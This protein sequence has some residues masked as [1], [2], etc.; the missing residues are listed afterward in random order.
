[1]WAVVLAYAGACLVWGLYL[2]RHALLLAYLGA[3]LAI[4]VAVFFALQQQ[5]ENHLIVPRLMSTQVGLGSASVIVA[6]LVGASL[7]GL[8]GAIL[9]V[10]TAAILQVLFHEVVPANEP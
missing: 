4:A 5:L 3:L 9:A 1:V 2:A 6:L 10:P 7:F 8:V